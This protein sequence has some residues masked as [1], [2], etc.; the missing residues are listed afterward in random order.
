MLVF[1]SVDLYLLGDLLAYSPKLRVLHSSS[2][3]TFCSPWCKCEALHL[4]ASGD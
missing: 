2:N 1:P 3:L 4:S